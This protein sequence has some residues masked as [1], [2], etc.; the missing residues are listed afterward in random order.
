MQALIDFGTGPLFRLSFALMILGLLRLVL[1]SVW[2]MAEAVYRS[3]NK[4]VP[5]KELI[6]YTLSWLF[7]VGRI[8]NARPVYSVL[9]VLWHIGLI[10]VPLFYAAHVRLWHEGAGF[11]WF[12]LPNVA[13]D[14]LTLVTIALSVALVAGRALNKASRGISTLGD[15]LWPL[16]LAA[17]FVTGYLCANTVL[18]AG[19]YELSM[20]IHIYS[21]CA[22]MLMI[23]FTKIAHCILMPLGHMVGAI[24]WKFPPQA[25]RMAA[26]SMGKTGDEA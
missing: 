26:I 21:A 20:F 9:S 2:G 1:L 5:F 23:P 16:L 12:E 10:L 3:N 4:D 25:G 17:P 19:A 7:P 15:Y 11:S 6:S 22:I 14:A 18:S 24:A 13:M 8:W